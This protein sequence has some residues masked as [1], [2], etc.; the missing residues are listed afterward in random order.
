MERHGKGLFMGKSYLKFAG[1]VVLS[2]FLQACSMDA[3]LTQ[4]SKDINEIISQKFRNDEIV[5]SSQ[6][7]VVTADGYQVQSSLSYHASK[8]EVTTA[9]GYKV[10]TS[11]QTT[12]FKDT[13]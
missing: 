2:V 1:L 10:Q 9:D 3:S 13:K 5:P 4:L 12:L 8:A 11:V 7:G 6:Q